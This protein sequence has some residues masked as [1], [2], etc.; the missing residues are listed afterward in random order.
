MTYIFV[1]FRLFLIIS[2]F[3]I[4]SCSNTQPTKKAVISSSLRE[5]QNMKSM[6]L[7]MDF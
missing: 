1:M 3:M 6:V 4:S 2:V 7:V 5:Q